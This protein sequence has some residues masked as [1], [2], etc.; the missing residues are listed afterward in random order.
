MEFS[1][2]FFKLV[3]KGYGTQYTGRVTQNKKLRTGVMGDNIIDPHYQSVLSI[4]H[5]G[6]AGHAPENTLLS[7]QQAIEL[8]ADWVEIDVHSVGNNLLVIHDDRLERTTNGRGK[9]RKR[10]IETLRA[11]DAGEGEKIP[12]LSEVLKTVQ[13]RVGLNIELKGKGTAEPVHR[14][15]RDSIV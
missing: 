5:R 13:N 8:G 11:L 10:D 14:L 1:L 2:E 15:I 3:A 7:I 9:L 6:A 12:F 4:G